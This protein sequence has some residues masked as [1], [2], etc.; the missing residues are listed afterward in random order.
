MT[1]DKNN[2]SDKFFELGT[3]VGG[4]LLYPG[5]IYDGTNK[6]NEKVL[7]NKFKF[8]GWLE[9]NG[10]ILKIAEY[11][12]LF[13]SIG[14]IYN[15]GY[16]EEGIFRLPDMQS[17]L[18]FKNVNNQTFTHDSELTENSSNLSETQS[19]VKEFPANAVLYYLIKAEIYKPE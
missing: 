12:E 4:L 9:A 6:H 5:E 8:G 2:I 14:E 18:K 7:K 13:Q 1:K 19:P 3:P 10:Q 15:T 17:L 16:E 11:P